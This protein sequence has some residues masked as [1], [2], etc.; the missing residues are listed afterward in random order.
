TVL[1]IAARCEAL[2]AFRKAA[3]ANQPDAE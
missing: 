1:R 2:E 3:P